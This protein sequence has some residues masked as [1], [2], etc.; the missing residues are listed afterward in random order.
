MQSTGGGT[1]NDGIGK[2]EG[3]R[4]PG[5]TRL[6]S[7]VPPKKNKLFQGPPPR[8]PGWGARGMGEWGDGLP[9]S[10]QGA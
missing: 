1:D 3:G 6:L 8:P 4:K 5:R 10:S 9:V 7:E 2:Q